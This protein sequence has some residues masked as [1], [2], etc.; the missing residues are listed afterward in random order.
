MRTWPL[1]RR[2][3]ARS[4]LG[5]SKWPRGL[6]ELRHETGQ[7]AEESRR[8]SR[9]VEALM[10][11]AA[12]EQFQDAWHQVETFLQELHS[13]LAQLERRWQTEEVQRQ[14]AD[15]SKSL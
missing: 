3:K 8:L 14:Q 2:G 1:R 15:L 6:Q 11:R 9:E 4:R 7:V 13:G 5:S 10:E 12:P